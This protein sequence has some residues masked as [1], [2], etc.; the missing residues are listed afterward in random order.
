MILA[1]GG[2][3]HFE[4]VL[5]RKLASDPAGVLAPVAPVFGLADVAMV[6]LET[7]V[8]QRGAAEDKEYTFRTPGTAEA[9]SPFRT[10]VRGQRI[11]V[12]AAT[13]VLDGNL[14]DAW[15]ATDGT[16]GLA[17]SKGAAGDRL[18]TAVRFARLDSDTVVVYLH[19]GVEGDTCPRGRQRELARRLVDA[20]ADIVVGG[21]AH[22]QQGAGRFGT[23]FVAYGLGNFA[24]CNEGGPSGTSGVLLV[25]ATGRDIDDYA[26]APAQIRGGVPEPL[27]P[28]ADADAAVADWNALRDCA[29]LAP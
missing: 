17:S 16:A 21:H 13:D 10:E 9:Y 14:I 20:G 4:G 22:R 3:V 24:F 8:T 12:F 19:W 2:D 25:T 26:W 23:A 27:A 18:A 29:E 28:G 6:N 15:T 7:A 1:F 5:R 11:A